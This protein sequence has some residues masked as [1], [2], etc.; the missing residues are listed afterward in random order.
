MSV[1]QLICW[2]LAIPLYLA[3]FCL[4]PLELLAFLFGLPVAEDQTS[5]YVTMI[6]PPL[7]IGILWG[8][9]VVLFKFW[10]K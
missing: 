8:L 4:I 7:G 2:T 1:R 9:F 6:I 10:K 5:A 3:T